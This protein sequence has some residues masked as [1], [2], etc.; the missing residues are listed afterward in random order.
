MDEQMSQGSHENDQEP[1]EQENRPF[2]LPLQPLLPSSCALTRWWFRE[3]VVRTLAQFLQVSFLVLFLP[4][5]G[6]CHVLL[7]KSGWS[8]VQSLLLQSLRAIL[9]PSAADMSW[10]DS[11]DIDGVVYKAQLGDA[12]II[13]VAALK[14]VVQ[15][16]LKAQAKEGIFLLIQPPLDIP[17]RFIAGDFQGKPGLIKH[18]WGGKA[19]VHVNEGEYTAWVAVKD[20]VVDDAGRSSGRFDE[21]REKMD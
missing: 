20:I 13:P 2:V 19:Y 16:R 15:N 10:V 1:G 4:I 18:L 6:N 11:W 9:F 5:E 8:P 21:K 12:I 17:V 7:P 3:F 14:E